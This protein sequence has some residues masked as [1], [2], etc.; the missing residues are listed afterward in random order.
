MRKLR[1]L[2][3][4]LVVLLLA[5][6][7]FADNDKPKKTRLYLFG[8]AVSL[9]D[10][11]CYVTNVQPVDGYLLPNGFLSDRTL[12]AL[13][14]NNYII[15]NQG[16]EEVTCAVYFDKKQDKAEK[17]LQKIRRRF[18]ANSAMTMQ[19]V[20]NEDFVF[21]PEEWVVP[22]DPEEGKEEKAKRG[23]GEKK[24]K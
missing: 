16:R 12:Y 22:E 11:V 18:K 5:T 23:K 7:A 2:S 4:L 1:F 14:F 21:L 15:S 13:Q 19:T 10:S 3:A 6:T 24:K 17:R 8:F 20:A 9:T